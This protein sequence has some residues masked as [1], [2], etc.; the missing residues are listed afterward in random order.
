MTSTKGTDAKN[1]YESIIDIINKFNLEE[2]IVGFNC[3]GGANLK[4]CSDIICYELGHTAVF[5]PKKPLFE[6]DCLVHVI[7]GECK[8]SFVDVQSEDGL[9][10][11]SS[12]RAKIHG[13]V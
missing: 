5:T 10:D 3:D 12:T 9:L 4:K 2:K 7:S 11:T 8:A 13:A 6:M 1:L